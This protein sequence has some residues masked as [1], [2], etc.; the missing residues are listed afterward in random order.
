MTSWKSQILKKCP[1]PIFH[2]FAKKKFQRSPIC[3][4]PIDQIPTKTLGFEKSQISSRRRRTNSQIQIQ[5]L[6]NAPRDEI[7]LQGRPSLLMFKQY[8]DIHKAFFRCETDIWTFRASLPG[9]RLVQHG[10][11]RSSAVTRWQAS[12]AQN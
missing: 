2:F 6:P 1:G 11:C 3:P 10:R 8:W 12:L 9:M 7:L 4:G 5:A